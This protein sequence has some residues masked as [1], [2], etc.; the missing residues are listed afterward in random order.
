MTKPTGDDNALIHYERRW[1]GVGVKLPSR[2]GFV[3]ELSRIIHDSASEHHYPAI[4]KL[5]TGKNLKARHHQSLSQFPH[6]QP[7]R[8][9]E[10][11]H[12]LFP[13]AGESEPPA[14]ASERVPDVM[15]CHGFPAE[16]SLQPVTLSGLCDV[17]VLP[18]PSQ[19]HLFLTAGPVLAVSRPTETL[20]A[21][22]TSRRNLIGPWLPLTSRAIFRSA[23]VQT[24]VLAATLEHDDI[25]CS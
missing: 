11:H 24:A 9:S 20:F 15:F 5:S 12:F 3:D 18:S 13:R 2:R 10:F 1:V 7:R 21:K 16:I 22:D 17:V 25:V 23:F 14:M 6:Y 19:S 8:G 4:G